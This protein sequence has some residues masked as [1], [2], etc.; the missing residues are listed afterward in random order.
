MDNR[1]TTIHGETAEHSVKTLFLRENKKK[2]RTFEIAMNT[3][4]KLSTKYVSTRFLAL[5]V[6][7]KFQQRSSVTDR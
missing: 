2:K 4:Y 1:K 6:P 5:H 3:L 7:Q